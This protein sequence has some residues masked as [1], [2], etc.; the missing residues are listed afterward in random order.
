MVVFSNFISFTKIDD[1]GAVLCGYGKKMAS[2]IKIM[3]YGK[4]V[5]FVHV[6]LLEAILKMHW[7][8]YW[9]IRCPITRDAIIELHQTYARRNPVVY[10]FDTYRTDMNFESKICGIF[11]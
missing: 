5:H 4:Y 1:N 6:I 8:T 7:N 9:C 3:K 10:I 2:W 11:N